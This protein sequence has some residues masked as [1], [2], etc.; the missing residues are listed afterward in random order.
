MLG[1]NGLLLLHAATVICANLNEFDVNLPYNGIVLPI[2]GHSQ[3]LKFNLSKLL[4]TLSPIPLQCCKVQGYI[5]ITLLALFVLLPFLVQVFV[6]IVISRYLCGLLRSMLDI[7]IANMWLL[8]GEVMI[9][10]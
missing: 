3:V 9:S 6:T 1:N 8:L 2:G 4:S 7:P 5:A 10:E